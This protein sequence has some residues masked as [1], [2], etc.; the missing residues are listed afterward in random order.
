MKKDILP[1]TLERVLKFTSTLSDSK[2]DDLLTSLPLAKIL[3]Y[4]LESQ[5]K[6]A[7]IDTAFITLISYSFHVSFI[8]ALEINNHKKEMEIIK[9]D[10]YLSDPYASINNNHKAS[11]FNIYDFNKNEIIDDINKIYSSYLRSII[12]ADKLKI[13]LDHTN[14]CLEKTFYILINEYKSVF[15]NYIKY[16]ED[17]EYKYDIK[18]ALYRKHYTKIAKEFENDPV[19]GNE[20]GLSLKDIYIAPKYTSYTSNRNLEEYLSSARRRGVA[21]TDDIQKLI[22]AAL[23]TEEHKNKT[24]MIIILG[25]PGQGKSSLMKKIVYDYFS[26]TFNLPEKIILINFRDI[27]DIEEMFKSPI[28]VFLEEITCNINILGKTNG[29]EK[30]DFEN[31]VLILDGLDEVSI[32]NQLATDLIDDF[33]QLLYKIINTRFHNLKLIIT[34]RHGYINL[35]KLPDKNLLQLEIK[36]FEFEQQVKWLELYNKYYQTNLNKN[37]LSKIN[38]DISLS[39]VKSLLEQPVILYLIAESN[40]NPTSIISR[41]KLYEQ[42]FTETINKRYSKD[43]HGILKNISPFDLRCLIQDIAIEIFKSKYE[44][45]HIKKMAGLSSVNNFYDKLRENESFNKAIEYNNIGSALKGVMITFYFKQTNNNNENDYA[46]E[47]YH[48]SLQEYLVAEKIWISLNSCVHIEPHNQLKLLNDLF[49]KKVITKEIQSYLLELIENSDRLKVS[50]LFLTFNKSISYFFANDFISEYKS[51]NNQ[52]ALDVIKN[53]FYCFWFFYS[54]LLPCS[55]SNKNPISF[56][57]P[58]FVR[59]K[60]EIFKKR[61]ALLSDEIKDRLPVYLN[62]LSQNMYPI[63][64]EG[65]I[66]NK[67]SFSNQ[68]L[69][70]INFSGSDLKECKFDNCIISNCDFSFSSLENAS[71]VNSKIINSNFSYT[72]VKNI[73][74][75]KSIFQDVIAIH[76]DWKEVKLS[77]SQELN[78]ITKENKSDSLTSIIERSQSNIINLS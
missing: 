37:I 64:L 32:K 53:T 68:S 14:A 30:K 41:T 71:F 48:K 54:H 23:T 69:Y 55:K 66:L 12:D 77:I 33:I 21:E 6:I 65:L 42:I 78:L 29:F 76:A 75:N 58:L 16:I 56:L 44:Y 40:I 9:N 35:R 60:I 11:Q 15:E 2:I 4:Y 13:L 8:E 49:S 22:C 5:L 51:N 50:E 38:Y 74:F 19:F 36:K 10:T 72:E 25:Y 20:R 73:D 70:N 62:L 52:Y 45:I 28:Q 67:T 59:S 57:H 3:K 61:D 34:S 63:T 27:I 1:E 18:Q 26:K 31:T 43:K 39:H 24:K 7:N 47:F 46:V 17:I